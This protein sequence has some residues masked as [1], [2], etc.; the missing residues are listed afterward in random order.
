M[1]YPELVSSHKTRDAG[2]RIT[3]IYFPLFLHLLC[4]SP[5]LP[6]CWYSGG[7]PWWLRRGRPRPRT[8]TMLRTSPSRDRRTAGSGRP[9]GSARGAD[10]VL[11]LMILPRT[12][13]CD[14]SVKKGEGGAQPCRQSSPQGAW[15]FWS[16][17]RASPSWFHT[18]H[19][20]WIDR[21]PRPAHERS[22]QDSGTRPVSALSRPAA[23]SESREHRPDV[24]LG[25][26]ARRAGRRLIPPSATDVVAGHHEGSLS[27]EEIH[28]APF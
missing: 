17:R 1:C 3:F 19:R 7:S 28:S 21:L 8:A 13:G 22:S 15:S 4:I 12:S 16:G 27:Y 25:G 2:S 26:N 9:A 14:S 5:L 18:R 6:L 23:S 10:P 20:S 11:K 24:R